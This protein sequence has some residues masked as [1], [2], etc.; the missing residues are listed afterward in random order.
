MDCVWMART[1]QGSERSEEAGKEKERPD[2]PRGCGKDQH[3]FA[4][5]EDPITRSILRQTSTSYGR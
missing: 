2:R 4:I 5:R 1:R 3:Q